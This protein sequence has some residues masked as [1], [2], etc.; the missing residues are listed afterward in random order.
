M[1]QQFRVGYLPVEAPLPSAPLG[2]AAP[3]LPFGPAGPLIG[4][5][6]DPRDHTSVHLSLSGPIIVLCQSSVLLRQAALR[7]TVTG[8]PLLVV[9]DERDKW[10]PIV[11]MAVSGDILDGYPAGWAA[12]DDDGLGDDDAAITA[13]RSSG[14]Q[15]L[16]GLDPDT[17]LVI[18]TDEDWPDHLP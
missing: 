6:G 5:I 8:R 14:A 17:V 4:S 3:V 12:D 10:L 2:S 15:G 16:A 7:A 9:T 18:D 13:Q 1:W 11:S